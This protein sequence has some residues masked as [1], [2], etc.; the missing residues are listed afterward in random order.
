MAALQEEIF[1]DIKSGVCCDDE[2]KS[3]LYSSDYEI[4][5]EISFCSFDS[6]F[7]EIA[8][9]PKFL[10]Y[11]K[12]TGLFSIL[13]DVKRRCKEEK[14]QI[15]TIINFFS[16]ERKQ[17]IIASLIAI[18]SGILTSF[19]TLTISYIV[20]IFS[21]YQK[22]SINSGEMMDRTRVWCFVFLGMA[23]FAFASHCIHVSMFLITAELFNSRFH[24]KVFKMIICKYSENGLFALSPSSV[25][26]Q[27]KQLQKLQ[28]I[29]GKVCLPFN[30]RLLGILLKKYH[31]Y[32]VDS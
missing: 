30:F 31:V 14:Y 17:L 27:W 6:D 21:N 29:F 9:N 28:E 10:Q 20:E 2:S 18:I 25:K 1:Q 4:E 32:V 22:R 24:K 23:L 12:P 3:I 26:R 5:D 7:P 16:Q 11:L 15:K 13:H 19:F 8:K